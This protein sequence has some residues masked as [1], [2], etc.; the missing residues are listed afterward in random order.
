MPNQQLGSAMPLNA[1]RLDTMSHFEFGLSAEMMP[2]G[3]A[4]TRASTIEMPA[5]SSVTGSRYRS[6]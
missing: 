1:T 5:S 6:P 3:S 2:A 4:I